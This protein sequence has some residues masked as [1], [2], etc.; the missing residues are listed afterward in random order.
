MRQENGRKLVKRLLAGLCVACLL[1]GMAGGS[2]ASAAETYEFDPLLS[3]TGGCTTSKVDLVPDPDCP[4]SAPPA[5][6]TGSFSNPPSLA[7]DGYGN[8][9][10]ASWG[11][12][13]SAGRID[14]FNP[15]GHFITEIP[16]KFGPKSLAVDS[17]GNLYVW[18]QVPGADSEIVRYAPTVYEPLSGEIEYGNPRALVFTDPSLPGNGGVAID[19]PND[20]L[21]VSGAISIFEFSSAAEGNKQLATISNEKLFANV[22]VAV[23]AKRDRLYASSCPTLDITECWVLVFEADAPHKL[24]E[25]VD[26]SEVPAGEFRSGKGWTSIAVNEETGHFFVDD[27]EQTNNVYEFDENYKYVSTLTYGFIGGAHPLQIAVSNAKNASNYHVLF[28]PSHP[29]GVGHAFA[30]RPPKETTPEIQSVIATG[31]G[32]NEAVL[33]AQI[34][35]NGGETHYVFEYLSQQEYEEAGDSFSG[36]HIAG[37][38]TIQPTD[39]EA[40]VETPIGGLQPETAYRFRVVVKNAV[41]EDEEEAIF[42]TYNDASITK[43][44]PDSVRN[45]YS[46]LLPDCRAYELVTPADTNGRAPK[47]VGFVGDRFKTVEASP[48]GDTISFVTEGGAIPGIGGSGAFNGSL[49][50][51]Q[52]GTSG[53]STVSAGPEGSETTIS[54]PGSTSPDQG[55][56]FWTASGEGPADLSPFTKYVHYPDGQSA[57]VGRGSLGTDP[58]ASGQLITE[59]GGHIVFQTLNFGGEAQQLEPNAP[60]NGT[61]AVY[62]RTVDEV[63]HVVSLLPGDV[64]P[65]AGENATYVGA[66]TDGEGI[67]FKIGSTLYLR[68]ANATTYAIGEGVE[69]AGVSEG[70]GRIFYVEGGDLFAFDTESEEAIPFTEVGNAIPVNVSIDGTRA[71]FVSAMA[72]E[73]SGENPNGASAEAGQENLYLSEEGTIRFVATVTERDVVGEHRS[74]GQVDGLGL[75][76]SGVRTGRAAID[77]SRT[78]PDGS[79]LLFSS[80]ANLDGYAHDEVPELYRYDGV[81]GRLHCVSCVPTRIPAASG[82]SLQSYSAIQGGPEPFSSFGFVLNLRADGKRAIFQ[83]TEALVSYD[84]D[85]VQD[86]YEWEEQG[87]GSCTK[88]GGCVYLISS[89]HSARDN[90]LYGISASGNDIFFT[91]ADVLAGEDNDTLSIYDARV[92]G[93]F[94][95]VPE[96]PC[97]GEGCKPDLTPPP[98]VVEP[99]SGTRPSSGNVEPPNTKKHCP[100][101]KRKVKRHGREVCVKKKHHRKHTNK[102]GAGK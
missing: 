35:P 69:F 22:W 93:G 5:S 30:F 47:G 38:G 21:F 53:W 41:G 44:C 43:E 78:S 96:E 7:I 28:V 8:E 58:G 16:D 73:G 84:N 57:L 26:G 81:R 90:Y 55:Y 23:D 50:R 32:A 77:P 12:D 3:L 11:T 52:R 72:I 63:T 19:R 71:Y 13:G 62:D 1:G 99:E 56:A 88:L 60:P 25:E 18:D 34:K 101:G 94:P 75:W 27:L 51:T 36:A 10:V 98:V 2:A 42:T 86:V 83:S 31:V 70:G 54:S 102:K 66:S 74:D 61:E 40:E 89:G 46:A 59:N 79:V 15:S 100:K 24:L 97:E 39:Q 92:N 85:G 17:K 29:S 91:T 80:R 48:L 87:Q 20:H 49:Y 67:A 33:S 76:I 9:F 6:P 37:E 14:V 65:E 82:A 45:T 95:E 64:T 4:Y 68:V